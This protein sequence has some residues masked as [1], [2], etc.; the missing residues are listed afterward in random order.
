MFESNMKPLSFYYP[1][2]NP[3][4]FSSVSSSNSTQCFLTCFTFFKITLEEVCFQNKH[5]R[6][7]SYVHEDK[8]YLNYKLLESKGFVS[9][10]LYIAPWVLYEQ[11]TY[12]KFLSMLNIK[13]ASYKK[14]VCLWTRTLLAIISSYI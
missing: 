8:T 2:L 9:Y 6:M 11:F 5:C 7:I 12:N 14:S 10:F 4:R 13:T 1:S 3:R